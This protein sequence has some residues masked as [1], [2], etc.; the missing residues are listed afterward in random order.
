ML[1]ASIEKEGS[2]TSWENAQNQGNIFYFQT[3]N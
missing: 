3:Y 2:I 1:L